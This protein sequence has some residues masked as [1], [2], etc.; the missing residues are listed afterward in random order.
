[1]C[2]WCAGSGLELTAAAGDADPTEPGSPADAAFAGIMAGLSLGVAVLD[3]P[4]ADLTRPADDGGP[5][6]GEG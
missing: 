2:H 5:H 6:A 3:D 4:E 1:V